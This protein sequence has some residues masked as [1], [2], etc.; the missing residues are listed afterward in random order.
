MSY[1]DDMEDTGHMVK[2]TLS[3]IRTTQY[4][5][6]KASDRI[7]GQ[8]EKVVAERNKLERDKK[9]FNEYIDKGIE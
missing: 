1:L 7:N 8:W 3:V 5:L 9:K 2:D 4:L 6:E